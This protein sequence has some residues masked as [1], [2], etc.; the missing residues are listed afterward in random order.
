V[1]GSYPVGEV[2]PGGADVDAHLPGSGRRLGT[3]VRLQGVQA[4]VLGDDDGA[5][6]VEP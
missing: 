5:Q 2:D 1:S 3:L 4:A 6:G